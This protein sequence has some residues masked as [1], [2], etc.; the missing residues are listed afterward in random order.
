MKI[1]EQRGVAFALRRRQKALKAI[2]EYERDIVKYLL[3]TGRTD[4]FNVNWRKINREFWEE[5]EVQTIQS[6]TAL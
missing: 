4:L 2:K 6:K 3:D 1:K 5:E